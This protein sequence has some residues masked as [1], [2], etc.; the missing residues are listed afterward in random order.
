MTVVKGPRFVTQN[1]TK[2]LDKDS[3][4]EVS[5]APEGTRAWN[6]AFDVTPAALISGIVT[7]VGV[8]EKEPGR[9]RFDLEAVFASKAKENGRWEEGVRK[10]MPSPSEGP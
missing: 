2:Q 7:E 1:G 10:R 8:L 6:P 5:I 4:D 3:T 9:D